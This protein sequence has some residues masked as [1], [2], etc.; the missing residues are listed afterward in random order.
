LIER[1]PKA[2]G[3]PSFFGCVRYGADERPCDYVEGGRADG[4]AGGKWRREATEKSC[5]KCGKHKLALVRQAG[6][7]SGG[8]YACEDRSC[9]FTL[10]FGARRRKEPCPKCAGLVLERRRKDGGAYWACAK[11][12]DCRYAADVAPKG[13]GLRT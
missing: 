4:G 5:P 3:K 10:P 1:K 8:F 6:D 7:E 13:E 12:P 11:W 2:K 9:K